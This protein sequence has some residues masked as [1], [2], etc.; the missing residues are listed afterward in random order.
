MSAVVTIAGTEWVLD[1]GTCWVVQG[2]AASGK[3]WLARELARLYADEVAL[4]TVGAQASASGADWAQARYHASI[5]YDFRTVEEALT[6]ESVQG[7]NPF[8]VRPPEKKQRAAFAKCRAWCCEALNLTPLLDR[9]TVQLSNGEQRRVMLACAILRQ[10][11]ILV[12]D[13]PFAGLDEQMRKMLRAVLEELARAGRTLVLMV[14]NADEI[15]PCT[16]HRL[17]LLDGA[18]RRQGPYKPPRTKAAKLPRYRN[19]PSLETPEVLAIRDLSLDLGG[20]TLFNG[21]NWTVHA[22]ERWLL[23]G[24]NGSGKT[25]LLS[26]ILGDNPIAYACDIA[27]FGQRL[28]PGVPLWSLRSRMALVS[29]ETQA[30]LE[31]SQ[32]VEQVVYSGLFTKTGERRKPGNALRKEAIRHLTALGLHERLHDPI[33]TLSE[34]LV[35]LVLTVR[36][37]LA[38]PELLLLDELC[39]NLEEPERKRLLRLLDGLLGELPTVTVIFIAHRPEHI[40]PRFDR[41]LRLG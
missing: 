12:L 27:C 33:G 5:E 23:V 29:P 31:R 9:W 22:G 8:E 35:R 11:P 40:P 6:Y 16:T 21:L 39:M 30:C 15:P 37:L 38:H 26:L 34:G 19:P 20:R 10:T 41:M 13:D 1:P 14:R 18:I 3:T 32:T 36:A 17:E 2:P 7:I 24:P 4:V 28:G 25:T